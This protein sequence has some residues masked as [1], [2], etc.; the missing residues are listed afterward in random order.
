MKYE[1]SHF[2]VNAG[3]KLLIYF[4]FQSDLNILYG[5]I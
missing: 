3:R 5:G 1:I 4:D 2:N